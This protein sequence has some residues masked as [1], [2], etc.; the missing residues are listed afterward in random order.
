MSIVCIN[1][2][3]TWYKCYVYDIRAHRWTL[4]LTTKIEKFRYYVPRKVMHIM[5]L[6]FYCWNIWKLSEPVPLT[7]SLQEV[8]QI[9]KYVKGCQEDEIE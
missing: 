8:E 1:I 7:T 6:K 4:T 9:E 3:L 5:P 2:W